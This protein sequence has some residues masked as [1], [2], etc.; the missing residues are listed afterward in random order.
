M[1][2]WLHAQE[3]RLLPS[4]MCPLIAGRILN[5]IL[6]I[7]SGGKRMASHRPF[8]GVIFL[9]RLFENVIPYLYIV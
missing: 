6:G 8:I 7:F 1:L 3:G 2:D 9:D 5:I 4:I